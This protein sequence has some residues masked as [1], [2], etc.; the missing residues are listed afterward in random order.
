MG[1][2]TYSPIDLAAYFEAVLNEGIK[3]RS[4]GYK[5]FSTNVNPSGYA[6]MLCTKRHVL[7]RLLRSA[8]DA[9]L[10]EK[11]L[12]EADYNLGMVL[13]LGVKVED[14]VGQIL[15]DHIDPDWKIE[16]G[17][18]VKQD[19]WSGII[20]FMLDERIPVE[21]K[22]SA[23]KPR[24][25]IKENHIYQLCAYMYILGLNQGVVINITGNGQRGIWIVQRIE[26]SFCLYDSH[27][28]LTKS[29]YDFLP[30]KY[31]VTLTID[32]IEARFK[33]HQAALKLV[34]LNPHA[35]DAVPGEQFNAKKPGWQCAEYSRDKKTVIQQCPFFEQ[36][37]KA[38]PLQVVRYNSAL[39]V[40]LV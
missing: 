40:E 3:A 25:S 5:E 36:C 22:Y 20:D 9:D 7:E 21:V 10:V 33:Q 15:Q 2:D 38:E 28:R 6:P 29:K 12:D 17:V 37:Y 4:A 39:E 35:L 32:E 23:Q 31:E 27:G 11:E 24:P 18:V 1:K 8:T 13:E 30:G 16:R 14:L 34:E 19:G 26:H